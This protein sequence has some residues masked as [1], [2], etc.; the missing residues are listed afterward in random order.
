MSKAK[1]GVLDFYDINRGIKTNQELE[2]IPGNFKVKVRVYNP[3]VMIS[4]L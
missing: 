3:T 2:I 4:H 1:S